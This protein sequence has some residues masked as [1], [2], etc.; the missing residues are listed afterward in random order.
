MAAQLSGESGMVAEYLSTKGV[1]L[2]GGVALF[3]WGWGRVVE[4][5][6]LIY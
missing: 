3:S 2:F 4:Q 6:E 5:R 1:E